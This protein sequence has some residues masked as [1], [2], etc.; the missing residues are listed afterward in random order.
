MS[1]DFNYNT[2]TID[3]CQDIQC[4]SF[5]PLPGSPFKMALATS[6][7]PVLPPVPKGIVRVGFPAW[8]SG[9]TQ[10]RFVLRYSS[11]LGNKTRPCP[12]IRAGSWNHL[13]AVIESRP[14]GSLAARFYVNG[15]LMFGPSV[16]NSSETRKLTI[17]GEYGLALGRVYPMSSP[18]GYLNGSL[19]EFTVFNRSLSQVEVQQSMW[20]N[21][22][23][24]LRDLD[25]LVCFSFDRSSV[26]ANQS[27]KDFGRGG[28]SNAVPVQSDRF[29]PW[30]STRDDGGSLMVLQSSNL[31]GPYGLSWGF[32]TQKPYLP[33]REHDY[34]QAEL[35]AFAE[36]ESP[37]LEELPGCSNVPLIL[38][39][40]AAGRSPDFLSTYDTRLLV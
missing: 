28:A 38:D 2:V 19:D 30:C 8:W 4:V 23:A 1:P 26:A 36:V 40:N 32:C 7:V 11:N 21:C 14:G 12:G 22:S 35:A 9:H 3:V 18:Y 29:L 27:F 33:G 37:S 34:D 31:A 25:P 10:A 6:P 15:T 20:Q 24:G 39:S 16:S 5:Q 13:S 17:A